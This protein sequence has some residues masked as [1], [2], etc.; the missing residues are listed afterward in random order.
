MRAI[1]LFDPGVFSECSRVSRG[2][3]EPPFPLAVI[4]VSVPIFYDFT[5]CRRRMRKSKSGPRT[6][7]CSWS[8]RSGIKVTSR[9]FDLFPQCLRASVLVAHRSEATQRFWLV[10]YTSLDWPE[11]VKRPPRSGSVRFPSG[12]GQ[13]PGLP[14]PY[15]QGQLGTFRPSWME[16]VHRRGCSVVL[17][18]SSIWSA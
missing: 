5:L 17:Q 18:R 2:T 8:L 3:R 10:G 14:A 7:H 12:F 13:F 9:R 11:I 4:A 1:V 15:G 16:S 6:T